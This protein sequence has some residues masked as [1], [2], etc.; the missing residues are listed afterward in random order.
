MRSQVPVN[1]IQPESPFETHTSRH[2]PISPNGDPSYT[3]RHYPDTYSPGNVSVGLSTSVPRGS[4][5][6][7]DISRLGAEVPPSSTALLKAS[8]MTIESMLRWPT[9]KQRLLGAGVPTNTPLI[10]VMNRPITSDDEYTQTTRSGTRSQTGALSSL[11]ID[12]VEKLIEDFLINN[13][14]V[15]PILDPELL[16]RDGREFAESGLQWDGRSCLIVSSPNSI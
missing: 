9:L 5:P 15:N 2:L 16:R 6:V 8:E 7:E 14:I 3:Q 13:H 1:T 11:D 12:V 10:E 4:V